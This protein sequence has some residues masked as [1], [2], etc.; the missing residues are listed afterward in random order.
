MQVVN[1]TVDSAREYLIEDN[2]SCKDDVSKVVGYERP[3]F[4]GYDVDQGENLTEE[5][6][7]DEGPRYSVGVSIRN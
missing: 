2:D 1:L 6:H 3:M 5:P 4:L 7:Q